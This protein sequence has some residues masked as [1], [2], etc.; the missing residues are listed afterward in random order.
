MNM[1]DIQNIQD[2]Q[3]IL[4]EKEI[5][6]KQF[7]KNGTYLVIDSLENEKFQI[8]FLEYE[9]FTIK[10]AKLNLFNFDEFMEKNK[11]K[12]VLA[13]FEFVEKKKIDYIQRELLDMLI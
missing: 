6:V 8:N 10:S 7:G 11:H 4:I 3:D 13:V 5:S 9:D 1:D 2:I 12:R